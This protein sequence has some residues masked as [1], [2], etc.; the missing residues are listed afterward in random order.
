MLNSGQ[1]GTLD[2][3]KINENITHFVSKFLTKDIFI[4]FKHALK[5]YKYHNTQLYEIHFY[6]KLQCNHNRIVCLMM[7][8]SMQ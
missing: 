6:F 4:Y 1:Y 7:K 8:T 3:T 5:T 2:I